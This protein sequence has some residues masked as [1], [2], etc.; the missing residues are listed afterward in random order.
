MM[1]SANTAR[2][3]GFTVTHPLNANTRINATGGHG[4]T[5]KFLIAVPSEVDPETAGVALGVLEGVG[6]EQREVRDLE[7]YEDAPA[8]RHEDAAPRARRIE[9][10]A[11]QDERVGVRKDAEAPATDPDERTDR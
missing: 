8:Q 11:F 2:C 4:A 3:C 9:I 1:G 6:G 5:E 10:L 7:S